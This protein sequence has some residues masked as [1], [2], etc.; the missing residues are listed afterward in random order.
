MWSP[1]ILEVSFQVQGERKSKPVS[2][3]G[4]R[5]T[6]DLMSPRFCRPLELD[7]LLGVYR[8]KYFLDS[9]IGAELNW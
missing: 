7:F 4:R 1:L 8:K 5:R 9:E 2:S 6:R 3:N